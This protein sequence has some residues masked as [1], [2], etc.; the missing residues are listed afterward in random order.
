MRLQDS[1]RGQTEVEDPRL[2]ILRAEQAS[3]KVSIWGGVDLASTRHQ[4]HIDPCRALV[5]F[6][7]LALDHD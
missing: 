5:D 7:F 3:R 6:L 4:R 1:A 2:G